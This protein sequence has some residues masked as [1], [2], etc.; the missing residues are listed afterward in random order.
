MLQSHSGWTQQHNQN[1]CDC[2]PLTHHCTFCSL[3]DCFPLALHR[4]AHWYNFIYKSLWFTPLLFIRLLQNL[5]RRHSRFLPSP[6]WMHYRMTRSSH[7]K[8]I[9]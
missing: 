1:Y 5:E 2:K 6:H 4:M 9:L 7:E 8:M 3:A